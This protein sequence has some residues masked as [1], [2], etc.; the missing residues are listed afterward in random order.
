MLLINQMVVAYLTHMSSCEVG[1]ITKNRLQLAN[2]CVALFDSTMSH[3]N[4]VFSQP[5][6][7]SMQQSVPKL[8][9]VSMQQKFLNCPTC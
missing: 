1:Q 6:L 5:H 8:S 7:L 4:E 2:E 3:Y 9:F